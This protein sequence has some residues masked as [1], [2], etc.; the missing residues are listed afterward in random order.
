MSMY[1]HNSHKSEIQLTVTKKVKKRIPKNKELQ[2]LTIMQNEN[3]ALVSF[4]YS[5]S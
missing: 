2:N 1:V 4:V 5:K 3:I